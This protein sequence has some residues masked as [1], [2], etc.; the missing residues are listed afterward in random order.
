MLL[1]Q[2]KQDIQKWLLDFVEQPHPALGNW[3]PC[4]Y[5]RKARLDGTLDIRLGT[6]PTQDLNGIMN[7]GMGPWEVI[8]FV[9]NPHQ[10]DAI[11][12]SS[13]VTAQNPLLAKLNMIALEDHPQLPEVANGVRFNQGQYALIFVQGLAKLNEAAHALARQGFYSDWPESY[14]ENLFAHRQDPR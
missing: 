10:V 5:A 1:D 4:P 11:E 8:A 9:Y 12:L 7:Q 6:D 3:P 2:V 13:A 14:L